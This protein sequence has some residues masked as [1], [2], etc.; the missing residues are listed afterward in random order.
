MPTGSKKVWRFFRDQFQTF[1][2]SEKNSITASVKY[3]ETMLIVY[4][5]SDNTM[6]IVAANT[7]CATKDGIY[8][9]WFA[10]EAKKI[11]N[12]IFDDNS[13][14][15]KSL[16]QMGLGTFMLQMVQIVQ[17]A[18][19]HS[20]DMYLQ[21]NP[22]ENASNFYVKRGFE[23]SPSNSTNQLP[24]PLEKAVTSSEHTSSN[25]DAFH[26]LHGYVYFVPEDAPQESPRENYHLLLYQLKGKPISLSSS[27][28]TNV[29]NGKSS[30]QFSQLE[31]MNVLQNFPSQYWVEGLMNLWKGCI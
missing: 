14:E 18:Q 19:G 12:V 3:N 26:K 13:T 29:E 9:N 24:N 4:F 28:Q 30:V 22:K 17:L 21:A 15:S 2:D 1:N 16:Q 20:P 8:V 27:Q 6:K 5:A 23:L 25:A 10:V 31:S 11:S 7:Y